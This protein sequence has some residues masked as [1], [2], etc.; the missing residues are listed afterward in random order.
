MRVRDFRIFWFAALA[1]NTGSWMQ[2]TAIPYVVYQLTGSSGDVGVTGFFQYA[3]MVFMGLVGGSLSD[4]FDRRRL[5]VCTQI[6]QGLFAV[7]LWA[8][9]A[10]DSAT[11]ANLAALGFAS[12]LAAGLNIP[13][14][15]S[16]V[17]QLVPR[18]TL[19]NAV[20]FNSTQFNAARALGPV[21]AAPVI[22]AFG[23]ATA[24]MINA[25]SF[26]A[27]L[28]AL[29]FIHAATPER[30]GG[31][32]PKVLAELTAGARYVLRQPGILAC[33]MA[34]VAIAGLGNPL[35]NFLPSTY[36]QSVFDVEGWG[37]GLL[38]GA[39][40]IGALLAA[41]FLLTR[42]TSWSRPRLLTISMAT[43]GASIVVV[44]LA[45]GL[46]TAVLGGILFGGSYLAIAATINTTIQLLAREDMRGKAIA[47]YVGCLTA[48]LPIGLFIWGRAADQFGIRATTVTAGLALI[49]VT[50]V[51][52][53]TGRFAEMAAADDLSR[54]LVA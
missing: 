47:V 29:P 52:R 26:L 33:C 2:A 46:W 19:A 23:A 4:R 35:F 54:D 27:V 53:V 43:Y 48:S 9:V 31:P 14:W 22:V 39:G 42:A 44:G 15:Q 18:E 50:G 51:L 38:T 45:P 10:S 32:R 5:L 34:I 1:S 24:F 21:F 28:V 30:P 12:G 11:T 6:V 41:P 37:L 40:G 20:T 7:G 13:I 3:P 8:V 16:Y 17:S 25:L 49:G 36:G